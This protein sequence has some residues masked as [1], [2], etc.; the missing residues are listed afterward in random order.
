MVEPKE[1]GSKTSEGTLPH[2]IVEKLARRLRA[3]RLESKC[4]SFP[5]LL[6]GLL[7]GG[8]AHI[9]GMCSYFK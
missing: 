7:V 9:S 3:N 6:L 8:V 4:P 5:V 2:R 1:A